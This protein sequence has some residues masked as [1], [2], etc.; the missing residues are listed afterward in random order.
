M[1]AMSQQVVTTYGAS[2]IACKGYRAIEL[3]IYLKLI[4]VKINIHKCFMI[5]DIMSH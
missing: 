2:R 4:S 1:H 3:P 5:F